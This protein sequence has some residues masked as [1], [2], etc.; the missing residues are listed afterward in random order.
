MTKTDAQ[1]A[2]AVED[3][4]ATM[5]E[6]IHRHKE[7]LEREAI[8][9]RT[10]MVLAALAAARLEAGG[11]ERILAVFD[12]VALRAFGVTGAPAV[13]EVCEGD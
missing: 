5:L 8:L 1:N 10:E 3:T 12:R 6:R 11:V 9:A 7:E 13:E 2:T 4:R